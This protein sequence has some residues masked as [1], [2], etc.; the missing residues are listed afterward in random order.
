MLARQIG[1]SKDVDKKL[2]AVGGMKSEAF[3]IMH[4]IKWRL[5]H[6][7][8]PEKARL[9]DEARK[10]WVIVSEKKNPKHPI[11]VLVYQVFSDYIMEITDI[12]II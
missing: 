5:A 10:I 7:P 9:V 11:V 8:Y 1:V 12:L 3:W 6:E 2:R 4:S